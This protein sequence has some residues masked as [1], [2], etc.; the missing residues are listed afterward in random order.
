[1]QE[2][3]IY[4]GVLFVINIVLKIVDDHSVVFCP[5]T[6]GFGATQF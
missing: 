1:M 4:F 3:I 5:S 6:A 2:I